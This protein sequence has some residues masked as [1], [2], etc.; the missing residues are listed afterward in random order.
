MSDWSTER[1]RGSP[2]ALRLIRWIA[3]HLG[4][5]PASALLYPITLY[6]LVKA[7]GPRQESQRYLTRVLGRPARLSEVARHIHH[8]SV[9]ILDR[10]FLLSGRRGLLDIRLH[11]RELVDAR[12]AAGQGFVLLGAHFGSF[13]VLRALALDEVKM[14][15]KILMYP[16]H[17]GRLTE[18]LHALNPEFAASVIPLDGPHPLIAAKHSLDAGFGVG[19]LGD[20]H[21]AGEPTIVCDF[22][23]QPAAFPTGPLSL[24]AVAG[25]PVILFFGLY[26]GGNRYDVHFELL[27]ERITIGSRRGRN[28]E[29]GEWV[30][31][32]ADRLAHHAREAPLNWFNFYDFWGDTHA[33]SPPRQP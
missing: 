7:R 12:L 19:M 21:R 3:L 5:G 13:E 15:L 9:T 25:A 30:R 4:R 31:R 1:E 27:A 6:F 28:A 17:N 18:V 29:L 33:D 16:G 8:F 22:L 20:R 32:Y 23:G 24:A 10:V 11:G 2:A 26:R 14:P